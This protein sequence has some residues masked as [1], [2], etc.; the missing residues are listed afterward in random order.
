MAAWTRLAASVGV[1]VLA[2]TGCT[3][4]TQEPGLFPSP[5]PT[6]E[7]ASPSRSHFPPQKTN[8]KLP[9][10][11]ERIWV[12]GGQIAVTMRIAVHAVRRVEGAT[13]LDWSVTPL[14]AA[15]FAFGDSLPGTEMGLDAPARSSYEP[16]V[17]LLDAEGGLIY[18]PLIH[19][20][21]R[22]FNHCLCTPIWRLAQSLRIGET[23]LLQ[24]SFASLPA[25]MEYVDVSMSTLTPFFHV[26]V[27][28][29]GTVPVA[30]TPTDLARPAESPRPLAQRVE[31]RNPIQ[32]RQLQ[33][34]QIIRVLATPRRTT[35]EW[36]LSSVTDQFST[37]VLEYGPPVAGKPPPTDVYLIN[38]SPASGPVLLV[39]GRNGE[40]RLTTSWVATERNG[41]AGY[42]CLC[43]E[44][45]LWSSGLRNAGRSVSLV[46]NYPGLPPSTRRVDVDLPGFGTIRKVP[47]EALSDS[48]RQ[49]RAPHQAETGFWTYTM[50][51]PPQG[52]ATNDWPTD[53]PD[54]GQLAEYRSVVEPV[55]GLPGA[56]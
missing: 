52:W 20:S 50:E 21:R 33:R 31:F 5:K 39:P 29:V 35:L 41:I 55:T 15:G 45:G 13:V 47:V 51:D 32:S 19:Q 24:I 44:L 22:V 11:G 34:I 6:A 37:R 18:R 4:S 43:T 7:A 36:T 8:P 48:A 38:T 28:P 16:A 46:T 3:Y 54:P 9:V 23:R 30:G 10:A 14:S 27:S 53:T 40:Q 17:S 2:L 42:E 26:P 1:V 49:V 25:T 12:S 56:S